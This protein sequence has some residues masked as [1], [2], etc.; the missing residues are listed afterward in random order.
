MLY[1]TIQHAEQSVETPEN[2]EKLSHISQVLEM[3]NIFTKED[4]TPSK[5]E[6]QEREKAPVIKLFGPM[7]PEMDRPDAESLRAAIIAK[8]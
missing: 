8:Q 7:L 3:P 4:E 6:R 1:D 5:T 2:C